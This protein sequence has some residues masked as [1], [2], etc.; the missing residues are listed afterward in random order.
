MYAGIRNQCG[1]PNGCKPL[2]EMQDDYFTDLEG[3][4]QS[5]LRRAF[6]PQQRPWGDPVSLL[7]VDVTATPVF[8]SPECKRT[9]ML[10]SLL[11]EV[12]SDGR[13]LDADVAALR[14]ELVERLNRIQ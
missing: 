11:V 9:S 5:A 12:Q 7:S 13:D 10:V 4:A 3:A 14:D 2:P 6:T 8:T 1:L